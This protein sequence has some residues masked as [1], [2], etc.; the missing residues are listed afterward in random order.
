MKR[1]MLLSVLAGS[2]VS[3]GVTAANASTILDANFDSDT[4]GSVP[5]GWSGSSSDI[6]VVN[7][8]SHDGG[9]SL[10]LTDGPGEWTSKLFSRQISG[11]VNVNWWWRTDNISGVPAMEFSLSDGTIG[12]PAAFVTLGEW[13]TAT[14]TYFTDNIGTEHRTSFVI[15]KNEW[16]NVSLDV[17]LDQKTYD[18][19]VNNSVLASD[20]P[21]SSGVAGIQAISL[22]SQASGNGNNGWIDSL[23][24]STAPVPEPAS[25]ALILAGCGLLL[26]L[27]VRRRQVR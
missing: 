27:P 12:N 17:N 9:Q 21:F 11:N 20:I 13:G 22:T 15:P 16:L 26:V 23:T 10:R 3:F 24:V 4:V 2:L 18:L 8:V 6:A 19:S 7:D 25:A 1:H 14:V 5:A